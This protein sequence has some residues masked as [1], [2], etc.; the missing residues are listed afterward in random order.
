M[1]LSGNK[2]LLNREL[3]AFFASRTAPAE[4]LARAEQWAYEISKTDKIVISGFHS[5]IERAVLDILLKEGCSAVIALG[6]SLYR[7]LPPYLQEPYSQHRLL[8]ISFRNYARH[9]FSNSQL[10]NWAAAD[11]AAE[12]VFAPFDEHSQLSTLH[13]TLAQGTTPCRIL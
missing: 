5:A 13:F 4:A 2:E 10:R 3:V 8:F 6:R 1:D 7:H 12:V 9:S 11:L